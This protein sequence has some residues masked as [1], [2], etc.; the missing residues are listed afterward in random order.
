[1]NEQ[2][3][4]QERE[5]ERERKI[6]KIVRNGEKVVAEAKA[7]LAQM[8]SFMARN[9]IDPATIKERLRQLGGDKAVQEA[10]AKAAQALAEM[11]EQA[12]RA[13]MKLDMEQSSTVGRKRMRTLV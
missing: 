3:I 12:Q 4:E 6:E 13:V 5:R 1:M 11:Q 9:N 8:D 2:E 10:E 7:A